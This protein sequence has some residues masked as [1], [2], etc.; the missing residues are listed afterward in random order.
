MATIT[1]WHDEIKIT[2]EREHIYVRPSNDG[3]FGIFSRWPVN[4]GP[5]LAQESHVTYAGALAR[6]MEYVTDGSKPGWTRV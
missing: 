4:G 1:R 6:A 3:T 5:P 2:T